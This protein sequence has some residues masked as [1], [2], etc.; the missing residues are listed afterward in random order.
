MLPGSRWKSSPNEHVGCR[1]HALGVGWRLLIE[2][3]AVVHRVRREAV[4]LEVD[5]VIRTLTTDEITSAEFRHL[6]WL[7]VEVDDAE[8]DKIARDELPRPM[9]R[10]VVESGRVVAFVAFDAGTDPVTIEYVAVDEDAQGSGHGTALVAAVRDH[11]NGRVVY[12]QT[13]DD[14]APIGSLVEAQ[15]VT[16]RVWKGA[17]PEQCPYCGWWHVVGRASTIE[18]RSTPRKRR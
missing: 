1:R 13:D 3:V 16:A 6:L 10:G 9:I 17:H 4:G 7:A 18:R 8:L 2:P 12:A 15:A 14:R 11:A 5:R